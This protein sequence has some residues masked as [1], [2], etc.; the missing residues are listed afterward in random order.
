VR[1][2]A[3]GVGHRRIAQCRRDD[4]SQWQHPRCDCSADAAE[5]VL[6]RRAHQGIAGH[7]RARADQLHFV[8]KYTFHSVRKFHIVQG[9]GFLGQL[10]L[11]LRQELRVQQLAEDQAEHA[12]KTRDGFACS[13][14][15]ADAGCTHAF[16]PQQRN[17]LGIRSL[18]YLA[19]MNPASARGS[20]FCG[21]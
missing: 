17:K 21:G 2:L 1:A 13:G 8:Y 4:R 6:E 16:T 19:C 7:A 18:L 9:E 12:A 15:R 10:A 14:Q 11:D 3:D 5:R 20:R